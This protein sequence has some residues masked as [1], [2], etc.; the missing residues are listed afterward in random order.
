[1]GRDCKKKLAALEDGEAGDTAEGEDE[2]AG[3][4]L[5]LFALELVEKASGSSDPK[6]LL[7]AMTSKPERRTIRLSVDSG[8]VVTVIPPEV[9]SS[10]PIKPNRESQRGAHYRSVSGHELRDQGTRPL[11]ARTPDGR[12]KLFKPR[13]VDANRGLLSV[14]EHVVENKNSVHFTP[15][16]SWSVDSQG[17]TTNFEIRNRCFE[18]PIEIVGYDQLNPAERRQVDTASTLGN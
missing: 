9:G 5:P 1:M 10:Y 13:V 2:L 6:A 11:I 18:L 7:A 12:R 16:G 14:Y 4:M 15:A 8:A 17:K 3:L